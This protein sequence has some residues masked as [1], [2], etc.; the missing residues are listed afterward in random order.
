VFDVGTILI[1]MVDGRSKALIWRGWA[2]RSLDG[3]VDNQGVMNQTIDRAI[4]LIFARLPVR[5][6]SGERRPVARTN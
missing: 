6:I 5:Q 4:S 2:E 3:I 1:D